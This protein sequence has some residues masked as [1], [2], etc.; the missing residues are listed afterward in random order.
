MVA[1]VTGTG[2]NTYFGRTAKLVQAAGAPSHFQ[3]A[4]LQIGDYLIT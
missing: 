1:L 3:K 4:V 2:S